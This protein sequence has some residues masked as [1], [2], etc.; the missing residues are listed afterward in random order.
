MRDRRRLPWRRRSKGRPTASGRR[1][2][3]DDG[4]GGDVGWWTRIRSVEATSNPDLEGRAYSLEPSTVKPILYESRRVESLLLLKSISNRRT[5]SNGR[6]SSRR[7]LKTSHMLIITGRLNL[8]LRQP[9]LAIFPSL[10]SNTVAILYRLSPPL[11]RSP[12][13]S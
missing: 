12:C 1:S 4:R 11:R 2:G 9:R 13:Q 7:D 6:P 10:A 5:V 8:Q 3:A